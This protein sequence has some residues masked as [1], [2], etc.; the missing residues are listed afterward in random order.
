[1]PENDILENWFGRLA[2]DPKIADLPLLDMNDEKTRSASRVLRQVIQREREESALIPK[3]KASRLTREDGLITMPEWQYR[4]MERRLM[5]VRR[6][7]ND[8]RAVHRELK[9][10]IDVLN[11]WHLIAWRALAGWVLPVAIV[12]GIIY[13]LSLI[14][15]H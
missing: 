7:A 5:T 11:S 1:M 9:A 6:E 4:D 13:A 2:G 3:A 15:T 8:L 12:I 10:Q 14:L